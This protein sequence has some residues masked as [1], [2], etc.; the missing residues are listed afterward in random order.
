MFI[1]GSC[2]IG[3]WCSNIRIEAN[4]TSYDMELENQDYETHA[5]RHEAITKF[6]EGV[7]KSK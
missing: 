2:D 5:E 1:P 7:E 3:F 4:N 6:E